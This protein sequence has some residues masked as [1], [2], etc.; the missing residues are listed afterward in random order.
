MR[1]ILVDIVEGG[2]GNGQ[3]W[4]AKLGFFSLLPMSPLIEKTYIF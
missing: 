2:G 3:E 1:K 4:V